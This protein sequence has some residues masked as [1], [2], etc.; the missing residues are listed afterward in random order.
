MENRKFNN[1]YL[2]MWSD[3]ENKKI[4]VNSYLIAN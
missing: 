3:Y 2:L 4:K 1:S